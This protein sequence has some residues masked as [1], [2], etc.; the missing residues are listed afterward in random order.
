MPEVVPAPGP[1]ARIQ[2]TAGQVGAVAVLLQLWFAFGWFGAGHWT[3]EQSSAV[4]AAAALGAS[5]VQNLIGHVRQ[6][7]TGTIE[8][9]PVEP[10]PPSAAAEPDLKPITG[11]RR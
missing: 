10:A 5:A 9:A 3:A 7:A 2:R 6:R 8:A 4:T 1:A 11:R